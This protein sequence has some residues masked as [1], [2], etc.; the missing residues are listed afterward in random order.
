M[1]EWYII[2]MAYVL[3]IPSVFIVLYWVGHRAIKHH[4]EYKMFTMASIKSLVFTLFVMY[5][6]CSAN[7]LTVFPCRN[8][9]GTYYMIYHPEEPCF[10]TKHVQFMLLNSTCGV[11][12][13]IIGVP[14][15]FMCCL[16]H[17]QLP[18]IA[19]EKEQNALLLSLVIQFSSQQSLSLD[20]RK[21]DNE[22][23]GKIL[24]NMY[25]ALFPTHTKLKDLPPEKTCKTA[26]SNNIN[27]DGD[28]EDGQMSLSQQRK[29]PADSHLR[30]HADPPNTVP[31]AT[32]AESPEQNAN[33][34]IDEPIISPSPRISSANIRGNYQED[35]DILIKTAL[36]EYAKSI[37][38]QIYVPIQW[39]MYPDICKDNLSQMQQLERDAITYMSFLFAAYHPRYWYFEVIDTFRKLILISVP[40]LVNDNRAVQLITSVFVCTT[41]LLILIALQ[42]I[43]NT[44]NYRVRVLFS[45]LLLMNLQYAMFLSAEMVDTGHITVTLMVLMNVGAFT[46][47]CFLSLYLIGSGLHSMYRKQLKTSSDSDQRQQDS[48][49]I[50]DVWHGSSYLHG[51]HRR[52]ICGNADIQC[53]SGE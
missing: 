15:F 38:L 27:G 49:V 13:F 6:F 10:T 22:V 29:H 24:N 1:H 42:P 41:Y 21:S 23:D 8:I 17:F 16:S 25:S 7:F 47:P 28:T 31:L 18:R 53:L 2:N 43:A 12:L 33:R 44:I 3:G 30:A 37:R 50:S 46:G 40:V 32:V 34:S 51:R 26:S 5:P 4:R 36:V 45:C 20:C 48:E 9:Y 19:K 39:Q 52:E 11:L 35:N 14:T